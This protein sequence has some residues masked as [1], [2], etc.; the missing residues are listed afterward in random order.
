MG[1]EFI[2]PLLVVWNK[3][4]TIV[5]EDVVEVG[6]SIGDFRV[7]WGDSISK[8]SSRDQLFF[9]EENPSLGKFPH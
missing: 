7:V 6:E 9:Q 3:E 4:Q 8:Q 1:T 5:I 2:Q